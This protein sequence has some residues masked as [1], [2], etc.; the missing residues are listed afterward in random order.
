MFFRRKRGG[1]I[2]VELPDEL[3]QLLG[4]LT[5]DLR[6]LLL[7]DDD[8]RLRRLYPTADPQ[9]PDRDQEFQQLMHGELIESRLAAL[10]TVDRCLAATTV[11]EDQ[12]T[13]WMQATNSLRLVLGTQ[14]DVSEDDGP[15]ARDHPEAATYAL[16]DLLNLLLGEM[17]EVL[18]GTLPR[19]GSE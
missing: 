19:G 17:V 15:V 2:V 13:Q 10:D 4:R 18:S 6:D 3:R 12:L 9:H 5:E 16:Y 1:V 7:V 14:L 11:D 8:D